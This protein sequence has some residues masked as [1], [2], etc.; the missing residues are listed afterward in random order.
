VG[1]F[2]F[3][4]NDKN[5]LRDGLNI[6]KRKHYVKKNRPQDMVVSSSAE[7]NDYRFKSSILG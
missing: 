1:E 2:R 3:Q 5:L 7:V 6:Q 4:R